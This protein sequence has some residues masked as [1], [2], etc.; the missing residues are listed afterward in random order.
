MSIRKYIRRR[1]RT[2]FPHGSSQRGFTLVELL[3]VVAMVGILSAIAL[4]GYRRY[5]HAARTADAKA[6]V[7]AIRIAQENNRAE[8]M[9]YLSCSGNLTD[10]YPMAAPNGKKS[11]WRNTSHPDWACWSVLN[12][13]TDAPTTFGYAVVAGAPNGKPPLPDTDAKPVWPNPTTE[14]WYVI[15]A[16]G[17]ADDD[18][19][20]AYLVASSFNGEIYI[21][22]ESE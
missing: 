7:S 12:V 18:G 10:F 17:D 16:A 9:T 19:N 14:P 2:L 20:R 21:E 3:A 4:V 15:Q 5:L 1:L 11:L 6:V 13:V 8:S 22:N